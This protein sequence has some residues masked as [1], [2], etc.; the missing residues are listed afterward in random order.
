MLIKNG[1]KI[2][3]DEQKCLKNYEGHT[4][5]FGCLGD[6]FESMLYG[7]IPTIFS[8]QYMEKGEPRFQIMAEYQ[9]VVILAVCTLRD[10]GDTVRVISLRKA[11][12]SERETFYN[13][14]R[15]VIT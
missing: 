6:V 11:H 1:V 10:E 7:R 5:C 12:E 2:E 9:G 14:L 3:F 13:E 15:K 8:D 4:F